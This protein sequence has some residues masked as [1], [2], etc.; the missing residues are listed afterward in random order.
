MDLAI[1]LGVKYQPLRIELEE[2]ELIESLLKKDQAAFEQVFKKYYKD[3]HGY[4]FSIVKEYEQAEEMVQNVFFKLW[5]RM[6]QL[7]FSSSI[8]AYLYRAVHNECLNYLKHQKVKAS[9]QMHVSWRMKN[10][11]DSALKKVSVKEL[12]E[13]LHKALN[14]LPEQCRTIF[15]M[16]RFSE[17]RYREIADELKISVKTV[18]NQMGKALK[19]LRTELTEFLTLMIVLLNI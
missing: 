3:L 12:E 2:N 6:D 16:S 18:E 17:M 1:S 15:Q 7:N 4:A 5:E 8:A 19:I 11:S 9:H 14:E 10:E 13:K